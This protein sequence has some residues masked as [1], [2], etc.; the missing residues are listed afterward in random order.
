MLIHMLWKA[1]FQLL[2]YVGVCGQHLWQ[3]IVVRIRKQM[4]QCSIWLSVRCNCSQLRFIIIY[5]LKHFQCTLPASADLSWT[6]HPAQRDGG[7]LLTVQVVAQTIA[8]RCV[9]SLLVSDKESEVWENH[10]LVSRLL[11][12]SRWPVVTGR[13]PTSSK[14]ELLLKKE[15]LTEKTVGLHLQT[16]LNWRAPCKNSI[17][18]HFRVLGKRVRSFP[19]RSGHI[20][21]CV[22]HLQ[23]KIIPLDR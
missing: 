21:N 11:D 6:I 16:I 23:T 15:I 5:S 7:R 19:E 2:N 14:F 1:L 22:G 20:I 18:S 4:Q 17:M 10:S 12:I 13:W 9:E 8:L 3:Y